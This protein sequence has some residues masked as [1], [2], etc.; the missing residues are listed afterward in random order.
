MIAIAAPR[1]GMKECVLD[2]PGRVFRSVLTPCL[3]L[4]LVVSWVPKG[5]AEAAGASWPGLDYTNIHVAAAPWSIHV[6]RLARNPRRYSPQT[7]HAGGLAI[8][9]ST[10]SQQIAQ[11]PESNGVV[12]AA[13]NGDFYQRDKTY[14]GDPRGLQICRS[15]II[16]APAGSAA[17]WV[18]ALGEPHLG[19]V[20]PAFLVTWPDGSTTPFGLNQE[21]SNGA[22]VLYSSAIGGS[23][24]TTGG[25]ELVLERAGTGRWLPLRVGQTYTARIA[26]VRAS[27][28]TDLG[29]DIL[30]L[31]L[32]P[33]LQSKLQG[34]A[35]GA[36]LRL[37]THT[38]PP[39]R[40]ITAAISGG[41]VLIENSK[42]IPVRTGESESYEFSSMLERHPRSAIGWNQTHFLLVEVDGRQENLSVGMTLP[43][44]SDWMLKLGCENA[45]NLDGG[46][47]ATVWYVGQVR[48][49]PCDGRERPVANS[50]AFVGRPAPPPAAP[51]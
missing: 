36:Q 44:L 3:L 32:G 18:D 19:K 49:S 34:L 2:S 16:S 10:L 51:R 27:G 12:V 13:V 28:N 37:D 26:Q 39:L 25:A 15:E 21:R 1:L 33:A 48:N 9:L 35:P 38:T 31:S 24:H 5:R 29:P 45:L 30:V 43:E 20:S 46:G 8:G 50:L 42:K 40:G 4:M 41:P 14:A 23:T 47:S 6:V 7:L 22:A 17:F 11:W